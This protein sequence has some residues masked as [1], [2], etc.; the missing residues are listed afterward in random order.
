MRCDLVGA[1][2]REPSEQVGSSAS[3]PA[4]PVVGAI[5]STRSTGSQFM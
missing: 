2:V 4:N 3:V 5:A 1:G